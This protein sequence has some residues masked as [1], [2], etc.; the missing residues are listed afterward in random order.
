LY[1]YLHSTSISIGATSDITQFPEPLADSCHFFVLQT[2]THTSK[3]HCVASCNTVFCQ[4]MYVKISWS[5]DRWSGWSTS[6]SMSEG[7]LNPTEVVY[8]SSSKI[9]RRCTNLK[10]RRKWNKVHK[11]VNF[12]V[13]LR[14]NL[15]QSTL[16]EERA[17]F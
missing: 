16:V 14:R 5:Q 8:D 2:G 13:N 17:L 10:F 9:Q 7:L 1:H 12:T 11:E 4:T 3:C 15:L 6:N